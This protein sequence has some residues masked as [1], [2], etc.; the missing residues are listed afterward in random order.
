MKHESHTTD[1]IVIDPINDITNA[2][3]EAGHQRPNDWKRYL[4][5]GAGNQP[6]KNYDRFLVNRALRQILSSVKTENTMDARYCLIDDGS[7]LDWLR[8]FKSGVLP[9]IVR[10]NLPPAMN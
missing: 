1:D 5:T 9:C 6:D 4:E 2:L 10:L 8:L 7:L 3:I